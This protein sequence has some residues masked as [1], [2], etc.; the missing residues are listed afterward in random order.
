MK[1]IYIVFGLLCVGLG[2]LGA[3]LPVLPTTPFLLLALWCF[4]RSSKRLENWLL[5]NKLFGKYLDDYRSGR[6]IPRR[7]KFYI[8]ALLWGTIG[9]T[10]LCVVDDKL[11][12]QVLLF[13]I[14]AGVTLHIVL[15]RTKKLDDDG[16]V[17]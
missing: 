16:Q 3:F 4:A 14:A 17:Q 12:L 5:T 11:W 6:G 13:L 7:V 1:G 9:Y 2:F 10:A 15:I 8:L